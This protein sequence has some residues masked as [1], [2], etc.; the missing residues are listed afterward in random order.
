M[1]SVFG[2][3]VEFIDVIPD[4]AAMLPIARTRCHDAHFVERLRRKAK[5][6]RGLFCR[7]ERGT[8]T[9]SCLADN[10]SSHRVASLVRAV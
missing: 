8:R 1:A 10:L 9:G 3:S 6:N 4:I 2:P 5:V 7:H